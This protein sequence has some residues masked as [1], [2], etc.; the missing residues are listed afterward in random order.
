MQSLPIQHTRG[1]ARR[2][3]GARLDAISRRVGR[4]VWAPRLRRTDQR[5]RLRLRLRAPSLRG[6]RRSKW[7]A[8]APGGGGRIWST[9]GTPG[10]AWPSEPW[11]A[12]PAGSRR[13]RRRTTV[14]GRRRLLCSGVATWAMR[15]AL[16]PALLL[17]QALRLATFAVRASLGALRFRLRFLRRRRRRRRR[18]GRRRLRSRA[19]RLP[20]APGVRCIR[21][22][23]ARR[24]ALGSG[25]LAFCC[26]RRPARACLSARRSVSARPATPLAATSHP[27][28]S[29]DSAWAEA[30]RS[31]RASARS[32]S[33]TA[34][35]GRRRLPLLPLRRRLPLP[36]LRPRRRVWIVWILL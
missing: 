11:A 14:P 10:V 6:I 23:R 16:S 32:P 5:V 4:K 26:W 9:A 20:W 24:C 13:R 21:R 2:D 30:W 3:A 35:T 27:S 12:F 1:I 22:R 25:A 15:R 33:G 8:N 28:P 34:A 18:R 29:S 31:A 7:R 17:R 36:C 19:L